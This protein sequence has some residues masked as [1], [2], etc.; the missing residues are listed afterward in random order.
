MTFF[1]PTYFSTPLVPHIFDLF[2]SY[3]HCNPV[4]SFCRALITSHAVKTCIFYIKTLSVFASHCVMALTLLCNAAITLQRHHYH[5]SGI[6]V[7]E[8]S[9][10]YFGRKKILHS[11]VLPSGP[12]K[13][14][15]FW[16]YAWFC[17]TTGVSFTDVTV[18]LSLCIP[19]ILIYI[20]ILSPLIVRQSSST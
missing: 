9:K 13:V 3:F 14:S 17:C 6:D 18:S 20:C 10:R 16:Q 2:S 19:T 5:F 8:N 11:E 1:S 7:R 4:I 12:R 15:F